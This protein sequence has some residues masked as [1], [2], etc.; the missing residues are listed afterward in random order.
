[1]KS[2]ELVESPDRRRAALRRGRWWLFATALFIVCVWPP[3]DGRSLIMKGVNW[4]VDP[5]GTLPVL[6]PQLDFGLSDDPQAVELR[7]AMVRRYDELR[8]RGGF[9]RAR[10]DLK[11]ARDPFEA[12]TERQL[13]LVLGVVVG[14]LVLRRG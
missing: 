5:A 14:F 7:D 3:Q 4:A 1:M 9:M 12:S 13:L 6:P 2:G 10:L 11:V 8:A